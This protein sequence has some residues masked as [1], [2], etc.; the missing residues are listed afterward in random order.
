[1]RSPFTFAAFPS[2]KRVF[3]DKSKE[4]QAAV[5]RDPAFRNQFRE[6]LKRPVNFGNWARITVHEVKNPQL[7]HFEGRSVAE[8]AAAS[9]E[10]SA[11]IDQV[12]KAV[13]A[14][15]GRLQNSVGSLATAALSGVSTV[16]N[17]LVTTVL[18]IAT[19]VVA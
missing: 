11:G 9:H 10:Q 4:A 13:D 1:M 7:K 3:A 15:I 8:I 14:G 16:I 6:E 17:G 5:Y 2:W 18:A 19:V 12:S